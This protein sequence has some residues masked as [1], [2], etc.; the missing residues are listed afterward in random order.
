MERT[1]YSA[2]SVETFI[3]QIKP[4]PEAFAK[5]IDVLKGNH[6][7]PELKCREPC[8]SCAEDDPDYCTACWG[9][10]ADGSNKL[11]FL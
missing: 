8:L 3:N 4:D 6:L 9:P 10:G 1:G 5:G 11:T 7:K 2:A